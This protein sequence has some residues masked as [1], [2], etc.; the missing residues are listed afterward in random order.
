MVLEDDS[1]MRQRSSLGSAWR[2]VRALI[3]VLEMGSNWLTPIEALGRAEL[4]GRG[5]EDTKRR[6]K[7]SE[8]LIEVCA[9]AV[10][11]VVP[12]PVSHRENLTKSGRTQDAGK[13]H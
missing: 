11:V 1:V 4:D 10:V 5:L 8:A 9:C 12:S 7:D 3:L 2:V 6:W 13:C